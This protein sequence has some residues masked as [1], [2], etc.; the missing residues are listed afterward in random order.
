MTKK[1]V[2]LTVIIVPFISC[3]N[4]QESNSNDKVLMEFNAPVQKQPVKT[5]KADEGKAIFTNFCLSCHQKDASG[6]PGMY[7]PLQN[8]KVVTG[9]KKKIINIVIS[10]LQGEIEVNDE[11]YNQTMP[12]QNYLTNRQIAQVLSYLRKN[13]GNNADSVKVSDV[14]AIRKGK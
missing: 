11:V 14:N 6:V 2:F 8:N 4:I 1:L 13:F 3:G 7:P 9:D 12:P 10:G 5:N